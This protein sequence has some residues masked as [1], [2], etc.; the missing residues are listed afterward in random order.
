MSKYSVFI[1]YRR[2]GFETA[3]LIAEKLKSMGYSVFF[4][5]ESLRGGKFNDQLFNV[6]DKCTDFVLILP[7]NA[8]DRCADK[9]DWVRKEVTYAMLKGK[10]IVPVMLRGFTW[11]NPMPSGME[12]LCDY[13]AVA[14]SDF[15]L[16]DE[17][18]NKLA[19]YLRSR[20][21]HHIMLRKIVA[22]ILVVLAVLM[23]LYAALRFLGRSQCENT[24]TYLTSG[25]VVVH[26]SY[27]EVQQLHQTWNKY[28]DSRIQSI[29]STRRRELDENMLMLLGDYTRRTQ[30]LRERVVPAPELTPW[31][32]MLLGVYGTLSLEIELDA[33]LVSSYCDDLDS[34][35]SLIRHKIEWQQFRASDKRYVELEFETFDYSI[36]MYYASYL[37]QLSRFP[38]SAKKM[39]NDMCQHWAAFP[40]LPQNLRESDYE[41]MTNEYLKKMTVC[42]DEM[43][44]LVKQ[45]ESEVDD[46]SMKLDSLE[47]LA[48]QTEKMVNLQ[49]NT[50]QQREE[51][52]EL[53]RE[54]IAAKKQQLSEMER[55]TQEVYEQIRISTK[56]NEDDSEN[57]QWGKICRMAKMLNLA[58]TNR[59]KSARSAIDP[60]M[61]LRDIQLQIDDFIAY[62]PETQDYMLPLKEYYRQVSR[63]T[64]PLCGQ[65]IFAFKDDAIHPL[66]Q[67]G[68]IVVK[69]NG[70]QITDYSSLAAAVAKDKGG[71]VE[72][73]RMAGGHLTLHRENVPET[74]VLVG[75]REVGE[76]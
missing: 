17:S 18:M 27:E 44:K 22:I 16:F 35:V 37:G 61:V 7:E 65:L 46:M 2:T 69:R 55:Q 24:A 30:Q 8:L 36:G 10:N 62:H 34:T 66:Y 43:E 71:V 12:D 11:P 52:V 32:T 31:Q 23:M 75:Y 54:L 25:A 19:G 13:Q 67:V 28:W 49:Q 41:N 20:R 3:N 4:D 15:Q 59:Q 33:Q 45:T 14:A 53:E 26:D 73:Y 47:E 76:Y 39:H 9:E 68:D 1:S 57:Y 29:T 74:T 63:G 72:F 50:H 40:A 60:Q 64:I 58:V 5:V 6:I 56:L 48:N 42:V 51:K 70:E 21:H 38:K